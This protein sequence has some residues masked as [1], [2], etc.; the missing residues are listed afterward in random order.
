MKAVEDD[1]VRLLSKLIDLAVLSNSYEHLC[2]RVVHDKVTQGIVHGA[3]LY[4]INSALDMKLEAS[5]GKTS[6]EVKTVVSAWI[7]SPLSHALRAKNLVFS[8]G[9]ESAH[10]AFPVAKTSIPLG[11]MLLVLD[12]QIKE[13]PISREVCS[14]LSKVVAFFMET[15][16]ILENHF[17]KESGRNS[18]PNENLSRRH[19]HIV[20]LMAQGLT[21]SRI[22]R[23]LSLSEST[24]RQ[25]TIKIYSA[26]GVSGREGAVESA[27]KIGLIQ[28]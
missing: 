26:L 2:Q 15:K 8:D 14:L 20:Q 10:L 7:D 17:V 16:P 27:K 18:N 11:A 4:S 1:P 24:I 12:P 19:L 3:H 25:E 6:V 21:N 9:K 22:G 23:E 5:H 28:R 13:A